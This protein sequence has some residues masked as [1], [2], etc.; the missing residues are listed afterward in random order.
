M[1]SRAG[2]VKAP[3]TLDDDWG[4]GATLNNKSDGFASAA[5]YA[6]AFPGVK[7]A[8]IWRNGT[9]PLS[10]TCAANWDAFLDKAGPAGRA[11]D[12]PHAGHFAQTDAPCGG[13]AAFAT[14]T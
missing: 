14:S 1:V 2:F 13:R 3:R 8:A 6:G 4:S 12:H 5:D 9:S 7:T 10:E 11:Y